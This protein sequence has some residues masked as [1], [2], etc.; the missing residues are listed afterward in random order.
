MNTGSID[1]NTTLAAIWRPRRA[2]LRAVK[3]IDPIRLDQLMGVEAQK[4]ALCHNTE[5]FLAGEPA[6]NALLWGT[7]G[8]GKSSLIKAL[9]N[10]YHA[11]GL[12][13]IQVD[14]QDL[15]EL[16]EIVD[17][18]RELPQRF[19]VFCD[20]LSFET[21]EAGYKELKSVLE[22]SVEL[23][24]DN[25]RV[26]A[27]S[28]RRH[29]LPEYQED[30]QGAKRVGNEIHFREAVEEKIS[31]SDRFGLWLS[32][33]PID[34]DDYLAI[35]DSYF[36]DYRG[37]RGQLHTAAKQFALARGGRSGRVARQFYNAYSQS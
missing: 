10:A 13:L 22:G 31:L 8:T 3:H 37:D 2:Y 34:Q 19:I 4:A 29:L 26:Y 16:P 15:V 28:N 23:P 11:G 33:Y 25:L 24:P 30:N 17:G 6:N 27:T 12:R 21:G 14:K 5:R 36:P 20:D 32:F 18:L 9:L 7:R 35:V 1:W